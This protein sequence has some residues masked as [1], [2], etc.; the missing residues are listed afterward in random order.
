MKIVWAWRSAFSID[1][2]RHVGK[3]F[4]KYGQTYGYQLRESSAWFRTR[5]LRLSAGLGD[6]VLIAEPLVIRS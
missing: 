6:D 5:A 2:A 4:V 1:I 3:R